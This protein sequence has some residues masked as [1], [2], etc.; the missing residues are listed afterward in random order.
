MQQT[1]DN[2]HLGIRPGTPEV[3]RS[4]EDD[5]TELQEVEA[6]WLKDLQEAEEKAKLTHSNYEVDEIK[7]ELKGI[8]EEMNELQERIREKQLRKQQRE[9]KQD[10]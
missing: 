1:M 3:K 10:K 7:D 6:E 5:L 8:E 9:S 2:E 4:P